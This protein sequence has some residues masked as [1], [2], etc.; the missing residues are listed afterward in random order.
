MLTFV[1]LQYI[2][3]ETICSRIMIII[4]RKINKDLCKSSFLC[5]I[6]ALQ[7]KAVWG[8]YKQKY[9]LIVFFLI[10][11]LYGTVNSIVISNHKVGE[12]PI[13]ILL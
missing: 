2:L 4:Y 9:L 3:H 6:N 11:H 7:R 5:F 12:L 10:L 13:Q 1:H 8:I